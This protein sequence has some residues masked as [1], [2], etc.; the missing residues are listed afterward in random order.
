MWNVRQVVTTAS[1]YY[2]KRESVHDIE[3][4]TKNIMAYQM[5]AISKIVIYMIISTFTS[6]Q[7]RHHSVK[8]PVPLPNPTVL[9]K[10]I[11]YPQ[12]LH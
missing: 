6:V 3:T 1:K 4:G 12:N 2:F 11:T 9:S 10:T 7:R 5:Y 8:H